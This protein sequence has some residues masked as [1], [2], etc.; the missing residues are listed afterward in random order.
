MLRQAA[1]DSLK[2]SLRGQLIEPGD[3]AYES[4]HKVYNGMTNVFRVN[5]NIKPTT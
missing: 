4:V 5:Q 2:A 3:A 1:L